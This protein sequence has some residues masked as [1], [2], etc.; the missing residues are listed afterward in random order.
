MEILDDNKLSN[1]LQLNEQTKGFLL[2]TAKWAKFLSVLG[3]IMIGLM[4]LG[5]LIMLIFATTSPLARF[6]GVAGPIGMFVF[7]L[8]AA[9]LYFFP[10]LFLYKAAD[11][12]KKGIET[13]NQ[14]QL[15]SGFENLKSHYKFIGIVTIVILSL[16][17]LSLLIAL[18][19]GATFTRM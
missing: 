13:W 4:V 5:G 2:E 19:V 1:E 15:T 7:W 3:F 6:T 17:L 11:G 9:L 8:L 18:L 10:V 16:Y 14:Q 12:L